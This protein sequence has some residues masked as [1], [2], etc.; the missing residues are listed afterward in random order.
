MWFLSVIPKD[1]D[2]TVK[3]LDRGERANKPSG[4][5]ILDARLASRRKALRA[6]EAIVALTS[7]SL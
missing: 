6:I 7:Q 3:A 1:V 4:S 5:A 2:Q